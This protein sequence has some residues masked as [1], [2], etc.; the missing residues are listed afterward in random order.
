MVRSERTAR[1][2]IRSVG[3]TP[4]RCRNQSSQSFVQWRAPPGRQEPRPLHGV[5]VDGRRDGNW[6]EWWEGWQG[7]GLAA[8]TRSRA[9][10]LDELRLDTIIGL[11]TVRNCRHIEGNMTCSSPGF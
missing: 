3:Q 5:W 7:T 2:V 6:G 1:S 11:N 10:P 8:I 9:V 4:E